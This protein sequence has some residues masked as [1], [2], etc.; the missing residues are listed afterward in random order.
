M[1]LSLYLLIFFLL[2]WNYIGYVLFLAL[3]LKMKRN[4]PSGKKSRIVFPQIQIIIPCF[5]EE[6]LI[7]AKI[8]NLLALDYPKEKLKFIFTDGG[9]NDKTLE[10][11]Q[12]ALSKNKRIQLIK[13]N[14]K[15]KIKQINK[16]LL[17]VEAE[18]IVVSDVDAKLDTKT[19]KRLV[20]ELTNNPKVAVVGAHTYPQKTISIDNIYWQ[21][22]NQIRVLESKTLSSSIVIASCYVFKKS[23]LRQFP[24]TVIADDIYIAF[25][26]Q[27]S[28]FRVAY[29]EDPLAKELRSPQIIKEFLR[30][31]FRK[32]H[33]YMIEIFRFLPEAFQG[34]WQWKVVF[35][36]KFLQ[37]VGTP[38]LVFSFLIL[39]ILLLPNQ[40]GSTILASALLFPITTAIIAFL[41]KSKTAININCITVSFILIYLILFSA[42]L[43]YPLYKQTASYHKV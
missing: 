38:I 15:N 22:Q 20:C 18:F 36:T 33:A 4:K 29:T 17:D 43:M 24:E 26:A 11:I 19:I 41:L 21:K 37:I 9:S 6:S 14:L 32:T 35:F 31:K 3:V 34:R 13:T 2:V 8:Q 7:A 5:N 27:A 30:H 25:L 40:L 23:L 16:A 10:I 1:A 28:G 12:G 39:T 42:L